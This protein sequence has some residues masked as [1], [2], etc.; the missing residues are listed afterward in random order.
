MKLLDLVFFSF[1]VGILANAVCVS[2][3]VKQE[4]SPAPSPF[5]YETQPT[6]PHGAAEQ[7]LA[8]ALS[9]VGLALHPF[10]FVCL[11]VVLGPSH[12]LSKC[13]SNY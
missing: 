1:V 11:F 6:V 5:P 2:E 8:P 3:E 10:V 12:S 7:N 13:C 4:M 9:T